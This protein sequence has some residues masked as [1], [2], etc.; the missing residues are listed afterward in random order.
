MTP[1]VLLIV[2]QEHSVPGRVGALLTEMGYA[3]DL[4]RPCL[5]HP[6]PDTLAEHAGVVVFGGP[7][8]ANDDCN[9][10][11][12]KAELDWF[13]VPLREDKPFLGICLGAQLLSRALGGRV[14]PH[15]DGWHEIGYYPLYPTPAGAGL[16]PAG[17]H[18]YQWHGEGFEVPVGADLLAR[19]ALFE[20][21]AFRYGNAFGLQFHPEVTREMM[22]RWTE[23]AAHR[24]VL[25]GAQA[26]DAHLAGQQRHDPGVDAWL[27]RFLAGWLALPG[28]RPALSTAAD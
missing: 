3:L 15:P 2:H 14:G 6:L 12:I 24:M 23:R 25:P 8:S 28:S 13:S 19:G 10:A 4:R 11:F 21:Q 16:F 9:L 5:G 26:R 7:M 17:Q 22:L 27:R 20:N 1:S 18:V